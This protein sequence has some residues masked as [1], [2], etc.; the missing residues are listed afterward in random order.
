MLKIEHGLEPCM[1][2]FFSNV[3]LK[4]VHTKINDFNFDFFGEGLTEPPFSFG[5]ALSWGF[6]LNSQTICVLD[7]GFAL[8]SRALRALPSNFDWLPK[9]NSWIR[10]WS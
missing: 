7:L 1:L 4:Y 5:F 10:P 8:D 9:I 2:S 3:C 6:T